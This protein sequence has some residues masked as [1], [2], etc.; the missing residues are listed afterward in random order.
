MSAIS[1]KQP[2]VFRSNSIRSDID[3]FFNAGLSPSLLPISSLWFHA[4]YVTFGKTW[5]FL[6]ISAIVA[7]Q[8]SLS[9]LFL[10]LPS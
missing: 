5:Q 1:P 6:C 3:V 8:N 9:F 4:Y 2:T 10:L 7:G